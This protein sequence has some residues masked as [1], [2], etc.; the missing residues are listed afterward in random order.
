MTG[1][2]TTVGGNAL[3]THALRMTLEH[4]LVEDVYAGMRAAMQRLVQ[5]MRDVIASR[6][7]PFGVTAMGNRCDL[8]FLPQP[9]RDAFDGALGLGVGGYF[10]LTHLRALNEGFLIIPYYN[11]F[12]CSPYTSAQDVDAWI[13]CFDDLVGDML[14][15]G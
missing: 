5:G 12:L 4:V 7:V 14:G 11:M 8:R 13:A 9:A 1:L 6:G 3:S 15:S 2:G 10:E